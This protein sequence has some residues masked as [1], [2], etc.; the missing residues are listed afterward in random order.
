MLAPPGFN[1]PSILPFMDVLAHLALPVPPPEGFAPHGSPFGWALQALGAYHGTALPDPAVLEGLAGGCT[2]LAACPAACAWWWTGAGYGRRMGALGSWLGWETAVYP[3][4][5]TPETYHAA[6]KAIVDAELT[7]GRPVLAY[8]GWAG[9]AQVHWGLITV[10]GADHVPGGVT[11][12]APEDLQLMAGWPYR[13]ITVQPGAEPQGR[14]AEAVRAALADWPAQWA[15]GV[16]QEYA[17]VP[18]ADRWRSGAAA[19][20]VFCQRL[21]RPGPFCTDCEDDS[22]LPG[23][24]ADWQRRSAATVDWLGCAANHAELPALMPLAEECGQFAQELA[25]AQAALDRSALAALVAEWSHRAG[26]AITRAA[27]LAGT[28]NPAPVG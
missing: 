8:G 19:L 4:D 6:L 12:V 16:G 1:P 24:V 10:T 7:F 22:C 9:G 26:A 18:E 2:T 27:E 5:G 3:G 28:T 13:I 11:A 20:E 17:A 14:L 25:A 21:Q 23:I 15:D